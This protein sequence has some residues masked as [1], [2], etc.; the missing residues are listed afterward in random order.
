M[1]IDQILKDNWLKCDYKELQKLTG[2]SERSIRN[3]A[4]RL[5]LPDKRFVG[6]SETV[7]DEVVISETPKTGV[8]TRGD[9]IIINW[10]TKTVITELGEFGSYTCNFST[11]GAIQRDYVHIYEGK[12]HTAAEVATKFD[13]PHSKAV[14]LYAKHHGFT[15]ASIGQ[16][17]IE[18]EEGM[19]PEEAAQDTLQSLKRRT[20][21][22]I[23]RRKWREVQ[24]DADKWN[25]FEISTLYP[26]MD[27]IQEY[28]P[29]HKI[30]NLKL[31][32][33]KKKWAAV[34]GLSDWHYMKLALNADGTH[35]Y[36][37]EIALKRLHESSCELIAGIERNGKP[38]KIYV[39][40]GS[41]NLHVDN[42]NQ[43]T[44]K[45][46]PQ[47]GQ[48]DGDWANELEK[49]LEINISIIEM[50]A[51]IAPVEVVSIPGNH[52][53]HTS[54]M[55]QFA[56]K[57][58]FRTN[59]RVTVHTSQ[60]PRIYLTFGKNLFVFDHGDDKALAKYRNNMHKLV[61]VEAREAGIDLNKAEHITF[62][63]GHL[64]TEM[65]ADLGGI[66]HCVIPSLTPP[67]RWH[68]IGLYVGNRAESSMYIIDIER[69]RMGVV[70]SG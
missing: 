10:S 17:D 65:T 13:F 4:R 59:D 30:P 43:T 46:T 61:L 53:K 25:N 52:D 14:L 19:T 63:S 62:Y 27:L 64:H 26:L 41:D 22:L 1:D 38:E 20:L 45:L 66:V 70:Y 9:H 55:L 33:S 49:Y 15:K 23:E 48:T 29:K 5:G 16:T 69:G 12:G 50:Y 34:I 18:F 11:H 37:R 44:T 57:A 54:E 39:P 21:K 24:A 47:A 56:I 58:Y 51:Q 3:H 40:L 36:D 2:L 35:S 31:A 6:R 8:E 67:D 32:K 60:H 7:G 42:P 68:R 28:L